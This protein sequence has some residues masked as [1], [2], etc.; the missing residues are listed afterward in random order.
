M[1]NEQWK[2]VAGLEGAFEV[3]D[4]G[5]IRSVDRMVRFVDKAG[6][7]QHRLKRGKVIPAHKINSGYLV[8][9]MSLDGRRVARTV[10]SIVAE[11]FI[12]PRPKGMDVCHNDGDRL[13]NRADNLRYD[14][15]AGNHA[16]RILHG[17]I[18]DGATAA[19]LSVLAV[20]LI[21]DLSDGTDAYIKRMAKA[22]GVTEKTVKRILRK[23]LWKY[24]P[25]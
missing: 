2:P 16:D 6:Q 4:H 21:R 7:E 5:R 10:H 20:Q 15:R 19:K 9:H 12:G 25:E 24:V 22:A 23:E 18:Y 8:A 11:A 1:P 3:S 17:T 13:N 14:T